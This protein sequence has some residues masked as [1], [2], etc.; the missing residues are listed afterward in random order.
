MKNGA[1]ALVEK[2]FECKVLYVYVLCVVVALEKF[3]SIKLL[4]PIDEKSVVDFGPKVLSSS[5]S[6]HS[7]I[8]NNCRY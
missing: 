6:R 8:Y 3:F 7:I 1:R 2:L 5:G 4:S